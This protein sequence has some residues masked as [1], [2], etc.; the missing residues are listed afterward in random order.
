MCQFFF[1]SLSA[2]T[3][4]HTH[5][6]AHTHTHS[7]IPHCCVKSHSFLTSCKFVLSTGA[8]T[9]HQT[10]IRTG[11]HKQKHTNTHK[12]HG[13]STFTPLTRRKKT[14]TSHQSSFLCGVCECE[15]DHLV[16][17]SKENIKIVV[18]FAADWLHQ[19]KCDS[20]AFKIHNSMI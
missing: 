18:H 11:P 20:T 17:T 10:H 4:T 15:R 7:H 2:H 6:R 9:H 13:D 14:L 16:C 3:P 1:L 5:V 12:C 8:D 19:I